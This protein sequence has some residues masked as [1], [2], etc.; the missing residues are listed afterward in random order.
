MV[1]VQYYTY[2]FFAFLYHGRLSID[3]LDACTENVLLLA[4]LLPVNCLLIKRRMM[5]TKIV[6]A[7]ALQTTNK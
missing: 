5:M 7:I 1:K 2:F 4:S 3:D 6:V